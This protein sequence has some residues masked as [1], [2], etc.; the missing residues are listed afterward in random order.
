M[1]DVGL[2]VILFYLLCS[3]VGARDGEYVCVRRGMREGDE[4]KR[5]RWT[6]DGYLFGVTALHSFSV[7]VGLLQHCEI[8]EIYESID[9]SMK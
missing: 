5:D 9:R 4:E 2:C 7:W 1:N 6:M 3:I 8:C